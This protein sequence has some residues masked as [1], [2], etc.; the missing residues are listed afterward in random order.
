[1]PDW[2][3]GAAELHWSGDH[4]GDGRRMSAPY[5]AQTSVVSPP[6]MPISELAVRN[7][8]VEISGVSGRPPAIR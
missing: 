5:D 3:A 4:L 8:H 7:S 1:M 2:L 6:A